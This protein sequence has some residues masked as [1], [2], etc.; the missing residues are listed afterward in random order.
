[1]TETS[2]QWE[3]Q[4]VDGKFHLQQYLGGSDHSSVFLTERGDGEPRQAAIKLIPADPR[5]AELQLSRWQLAANLLHPHLIRL[6]EMGRC[7]VGNQDMLYVV[8]E[9]AAENLLQVLPDRP[10]TPAETR[11]ML[12]PTLQVLAYLHGKNLAHGH[13]K[14]GNIMAIDDRLK[15]SSDGICAVGELSAR[16]DEPDVYEAPEVAKTGKF[17]AGDIWSLGVTLVEVLTQHLPRWE[18]TDREEPILPETLPAP[19]VDIARLCLRRDPRLRCT[20]ADIA[21]LLRPPSSVPTTSVSAKPGKAPGKQRY[22][23]PAIAAVLALAIILAAP[24]LVHKRP[25]SGQTSS[26]ASEQ[27]KPKRQPEKSETGQPVRKVTDRQALSDGGAVSP[28]PVR[29]TK[30]VN[31]H[32]GSSVRGEVAHQVLPDVPQKA[33]DSIRGT[34]KVRIRVQVDPSGSVVGTSLDSP[35]PSKYFA[36][37]AAD[38]SRR[39]KFT[40]ARIDGQNAPSEWI[41]RFEFTQAD[42]KVTPVQTAP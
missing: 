19:F 1:M 41:L 2:K 14:P 33:R 28:A 26:V 8:M 13:I 11:D 29:L 40:P 18:R 38:A 27:P 30:G 16:R 22:I 24:R 4:L 6:F 3:A 21:A 37:L 35:G 31:T 17:P 9:Y 15:I 39:W 5:S 7:Q 36:N 34:L 42:T 32:A 23:V 25:E 12:R 10:L 20:V